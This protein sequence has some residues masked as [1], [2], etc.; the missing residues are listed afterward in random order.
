MGAA[1]LKITTTTKKEEV[2][3]RLNECFCQ[4]SVTNFIFIFVVF[5]IQKSAL[6]TQIFKK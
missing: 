6:Y 3:N 5:C 4:A 1:D 2:L